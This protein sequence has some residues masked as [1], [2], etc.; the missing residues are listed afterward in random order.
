MNIRKQVNRLKFGW[1]STCVFAVCVLIIVFCEYIKWDGRELFFSLA[2]SA[3]P[4]SGIL[5]MTNYLLSENEELSDWGLD[6]IYETRATINGECAEKLENVR[7]HLD[8][9]AFGLSSFRSKN[10][11]DIAGVLEHNVNIRILTMNP[12]DRKRYIE[13]RAC[14]EGQLPENIRNDVKNLVQWAR[15]LNKKSTKGKICVRGYNC[16]TLDFYWREDSDLY[17]GPYLYG[18]GSQQTVT[19]K[20]LPGKKGFLMYTRYFDNLWK[21][22]EHVVLVGENSI[23]LEK[24][25]AMLKKT[26]D[27]VG[28]KKNIKYR[29][30][31]MKGTK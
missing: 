7:E 30:R 8:I 9:I 10:G 2:C 23:D 14:E 31:D 19:Y 17:V 15:D 13:Q 4:A 16:M 29:K 20:F 24:E 22:C 25:L 11:D 5:F 6:K 1:F 3:L 27:S 18:C 28:S 26:S 21:K 12:V